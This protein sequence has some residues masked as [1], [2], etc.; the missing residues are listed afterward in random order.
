MKYDDE[1]PEMTGWGRCLRS[2][3]LT[4]L[5]ERISAEAIADAA[6]PGGDRLYL[7]GL[8]MALRH[9]FRVDQDND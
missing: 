8:R 2:R 9:L 4:D 7:P 1:F 5:A 6:R 3:K